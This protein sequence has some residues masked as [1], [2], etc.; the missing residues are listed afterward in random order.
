MVLSQRTSIPALLVLWQ[1]VDTV[2][3]QQCREEYSIYGM[4]LKR[5]TFKK[6]KASNWSACIQACEGDI[7]CQSINYVIGQEMCELN[8]RTKEARPADF[9]PDEKRSY[10]KRFNKRG[11]S[12][13]TFVYV[14]CIFLSY[15]WYVNLYVSTVT[16][17]SIP[18]LPA[19]SCAEIK[20]SEGDNAASDNYWFDSIKPGETVLKPCNIEGMYQY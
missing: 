11:I 8:K 13:C 16:L 10:M 3:A 14:T 9:V 4:K 5:H 7:R 19:E 1:T 6:T 15:W 18:E 2:S 12:T 20:A 17:G